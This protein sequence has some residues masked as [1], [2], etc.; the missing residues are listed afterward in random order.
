MH[1]AKLDIQGNSLVG[2]YIVPMD[3]IVLVGPEISKK[4]RRIIESV[5]K[6]ETVALTIAGTGLIGVFAATNGSVLVVPEIIFPHEEQILKEAGVNYRKIKTTLTC[7][8]NNIV[9]SRKGVL[10]NPGF[11]EEALS[12]LQ[13][14]F[15]LPFKVFSLGDIPTIGSFI[16]C[17]SKYGLCSHDFS[18]EDISSIEKHLGIQLTTGTVNLGSTQVK[19]GLAVN[20]AGFVI[21]AS[22]GGPE[23]INADEALGFLE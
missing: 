10:L 9:A 7:L 17:N 16:V 5:F 3:D 12:Q 1:V 4:D 2:L 23:I 14:A 20:D 15:S 11:E 13:E 21:G 6:V 18:D 19:S 8:G 22:S